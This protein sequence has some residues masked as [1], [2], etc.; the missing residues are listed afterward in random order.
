MKGCEMSESLSALGL[1]RKTLISDQRSAMVLAFMYGFYCQFFLTYWNFLSSRSPNQTNAFRYTLQQ[2]SQDGHSNIVVVINF[3]K[4]DAP[5]SEAEDSAHAVVALTNNS[6]VAFAEVFGIKGTKIS[7]C[8]EKKGLP[9]P[10]EINP[11]SGALAQF[12]MAKGNSADWTVSDVIEYAEL[13]SLALDPFMT[14]YGL[15]T[16][17]GYLKSMATKAGRFESQGK[18]IHPDL[19]I[20]NPRSR[21]QFLGMISAL[22]NV[23]PGEIM[24]LKKPEELAGFVDVAL[25]VQSSLPKF[26]ASIESPLLPSPVKQ[27]SKLERQQGAVMDML[28]SLK[29][30]EGLQAKEISEKMPAHLRAAESSV[31]RHVIPPLVKTGQIKN[32][33]GIGYHI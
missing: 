30:D 28:R 29:P 8:D 25:H 1:S 12:V 32:T 20:L 17:A 26:I 23:Q 15:P 22:I 9:D 11:H 18:R 5:L 27:R 6:W 3:C 2:L 33:A 4:G 7:Q 13:V 19:N 16:L 10:E 24:R 21:S 31:R 14:F